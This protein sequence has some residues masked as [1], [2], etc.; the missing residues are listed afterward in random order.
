[1][2]REYVCLTKNSNENGLIGLSLSTFEQIAKLSIE[3]MKNVRLAGTSRFSNN[4][5]CK[6]VN[7]QIILNLN[8]LIKAGVNVNE[9]CRQ[10]QQN[11]TEYIRRMTDFAGV[12]VNVNITGFY[13]A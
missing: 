10:I 12:N 11:I 13:L 7:G 5:S 6:V 2:A 1:M 4:C 8:V 9:Y 3:D